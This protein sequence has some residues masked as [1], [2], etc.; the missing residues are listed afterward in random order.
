MY[1]IRINNTGTN[2]LI[3]GGSSMWT[4]LN[5]INSVA[6]GTVSITSDKL[7]ILRGD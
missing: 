2:K 5:S 3:F 1:N 7:T 6:N 4:Y